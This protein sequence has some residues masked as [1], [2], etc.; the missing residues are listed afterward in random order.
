LNQ[1]ATISLLSV[2]AIGAAGCKPHARIDACAAQRVQGATR[3]AKPQPDLSGCT[4]FGKA[5]FY[6]K[7][8]SNKKM[9]DGIRMNP[10]GD[11]AASRTLPLGT[12]ARVTNLATGR[13]AVVLIQDRGP[14]VKGRILDLSPATARTI[15]IT[16]TE[17]IANVKV[18]PLLVPLP[19]GRTKRPRTH[20]RT[21]Q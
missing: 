20:G 6:A 3:A 2:I 13:S 1:L 17:G 5:S 21:H 10:R 4:R 9:A 7:R 8:F 11:N 14:Y 16:R 18:A 15:G 19:D 12:T